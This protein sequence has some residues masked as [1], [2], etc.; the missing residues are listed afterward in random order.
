[1]KKLAYI[2][3]LL[4][5]FVVNASAD[6]DLLSKAEKAYDSKKYKDAIVSYE[7]LIKD[8]FKS[9]QLYFNLGNAYYRDNQ[10]GKAIYNYE[11][12]RKLNPNDEDVR[13]NLGIASAKTSDKID[14]KE[15]FFVSAVKTNVLSSFNTTGWAWITVACTVIFCL[16]TFVFIGSGNVLLK[17]ISFF[18]AAASLIGFICTYFLGYSAMKSKYDNTFAIILAKE[19]KI[20]NEPTSTA[21]SKFSLHE[22]TKIR[23]V[24]NNGDWVLIKLDNGNEGWVKLADVGII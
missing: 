14:S 5:A 6:N 18:L 11:L 2:F 10:L 7:E 16:L 8:G 1:M 21:S 3:I 9:Y 15:N 22:G 17:R 23:V 19:V 24:E 20:K 13:I 12:A 4:F